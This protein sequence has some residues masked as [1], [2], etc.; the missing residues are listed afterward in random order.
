MCVLRLQERAYALSAFVSQLLNSVLVLL[1]VNAHSDKASNAIKAGLASG[2]DSRSQA[3]IDGQIQFAG[4]LA[5][6][7]GL[8][9]VAVEICTYWYSL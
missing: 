9:E 4:C 7:P 6:R 1:L 5:V 8:G 2:G 3:C